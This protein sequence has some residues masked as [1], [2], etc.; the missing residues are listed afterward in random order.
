[1]RIHNTRSFG[2]LKDPMISWRGVSFRVRVRAV[3][4]ET[5]GEL[6]VTRGAPAFC[7]LQAKVRRERHSEAWEAVDDRPG[8]LGAAGAA[9][10]PSDDRG[11]VVAVVNTQSRPVDLDAAHATACSMTML[12]FPSP[13]RIRRETGERA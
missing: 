8:R 7:P 6:A 2:L 11:R 9:R 13:A 1:M 12:V 4:S 3:R 5:A 10:Q